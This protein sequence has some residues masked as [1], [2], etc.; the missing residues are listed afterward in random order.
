MD[1]LWCVRVFFVSCVVGV[2]GLG[3]VRPLPVHVLD[4]KDFPTIDMTCRV[5]H[6]DTHRKLGAF[7]GN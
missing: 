3:G 5:W 7:V 2:G 1:Y 6:K 4:D